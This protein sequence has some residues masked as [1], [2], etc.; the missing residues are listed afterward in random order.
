MSDNTQNPSNEDPTPVNPHLERPP[1]DPENPVDIIRRRIHTATDAIMTMLYVAE[2]TLPAEAL[3][4]E[5][6]LILELEAIYAEVRA[7]H[8]YTIQP[9]SVQPVLSPEELVG[10]VEQA[11]ADHFE[12]RFS[13]F[14][15]PD[16]GQTNLFGDKVV[17]IAENPG[18]DAPEPDPQIG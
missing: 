7:V 16:L 8:D 5:V 4:T 13:G 11:I 6:G 3:G 15:T 1:Y 10:R 14:T 9:M 12:A 17:Q 18:S 2:S